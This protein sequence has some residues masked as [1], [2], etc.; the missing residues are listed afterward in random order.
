MPNR[1]EVS[2]RNSRGERE[3]PRMQLSPWAPRKTLKVF[4][5]TRHPP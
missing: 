4:P 2:E 3:G 1:V 5:P